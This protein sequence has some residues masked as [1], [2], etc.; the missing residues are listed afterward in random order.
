MNI[1]WGT[2]ADTILKRGDGG[3]EYH[4]KATYS[5]EASQYY[6]RIWRKYGALGKEPSYPKFEFWEDYED[7]F[8]QRQRVYYEIRLYKD[9]EGY[10]N[11]SDVGHDIGRWVDEGAY[12]RIMSQWKEVKAGIDPIVGTNTRSDFI[13]VSDSL[14]NV[15][16]FEPLDT[17]LEFVFGEKA[18]VGLICSF[19]DS[20]QEGKGI[21]GRCCLDAPY[22]TS[23]PWGQAYSCD[24]PCGNDGPTLGGLD[25]LSLIHI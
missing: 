23:A 13:Y 17:A 20:L 12:Y 1:N 11:P 21:P 6:F 24:D 8:M 2:H 25:E 22:Q 14:F 7:P 18:S 3:G 16:D 5:Y 4:R 10:V 19:A 15:E 9:V